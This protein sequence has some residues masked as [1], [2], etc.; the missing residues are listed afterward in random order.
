MT[1]I[2]HHHIMTLL[3]ARIT[4]QNDDFNSYDNKAQG[5]ISISSVLV[6]LISG[7]GLIPDTTNQISITG[8]FVMLVVFARLTYHALRV[9][10]ITKWERLFTITTSE[11]FMTEDYLQIIAVPEDRYIK[12]AVAM[13]TKIIEKNQM[14]LDEKLSSLKLAW[15][16]LVYLLVASFIYAFVLILL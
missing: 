10:K 9:M 6:A 13:L 4:S 1:K 5:I 2:N 11:K 7:F 16:W 15:K 8:F 3:E 14:T 12:D